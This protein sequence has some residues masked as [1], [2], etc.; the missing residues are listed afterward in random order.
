MMKSDL[1]GLG[2]GLERGADPVILDGLVDGILLILKYRIE[3]NGTKL[4]FMED[5]GEGQGRKKWAEL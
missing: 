5:E 4:F 3:L 1:G 2:D